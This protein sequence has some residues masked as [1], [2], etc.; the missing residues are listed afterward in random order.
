M[1]GLGAFL[2]SAWQLAIPYYKSEERWFARGLLA[3]IIA[4]NLLLVA[5]NVLLNFWNGQFFD[6]LQ[7][8]D[9]DGFISLLVF[10]RT[11][12]NGWM[13]GFT[14]IVLIYIPIAIYRTYLRQ[15][16]QIRW[17]GWL[18]ASLTERW[19]SDRAYYRISLL[20][21]PTGT[22]T[23]NPDQRIADDVRT[24]VDDA[25]I[26]GLDLLTNLVTLFSFL[27][28]LWTLSGTV[29]LLGV[30]IPG[31][32][33]WVALVYSVLG[34]GLAHL[35]GWPLT[36]INF[37]QER[38]EADFRFSLTRVRENTEGIALYG[39]EA[40]ERRT[41][42]GRFA[43]IAANWYQLIWRTKLL[44][45]FISGYSQVANIFPFV[46]AAPRYFAGEI[47][48]GG[49]TRTASAFG[50]VQD[51]MSWFITSYSRLASW[52]ATVN[53]LTS[54]EQA[55]STAKLLAGEG[56]KLVPGEG[57]GLRLDGVTLRLPDG[58]LLIDGAQAS[59]PAGQ[60]T[61]IQGRSGS[62]KSTLFRALAGI[63]PFG[64]G[65]IERPAGSY[66]FIPQRSYIPLGTLRHAITYPAPAESFDDARVTQAL[67]DAGLDALRDQ[68]DEDAQW[69]QRL[70]GG[71]QQRLALARA[72][73]LRPDWLF[74]DEATANLDPEA[75]AKLYECLRT[76]LPGT[77][78]ISIA[79]RTTV[80]DLHDHK[81]VFRR[82][83]GKPGNL[84]PA[85]PAAA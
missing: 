29:T 60:S 73:L 31:Y 67:S 33:V 83:V 14:L 28:V 25:L 52:Q 62:G 23:D 58:S 64:A 51:A 68:L 10:G 6:T 76:R 44:N 35:V 1:R 63:W 17:R 34:T 22:G 70:S 74:L 55:I 48:L 53:R 8:K 26:L 66:L 20:G 54:F 16:L 38:F 27:S 65:Q 50:Q 84:A 3:A 47:T 79:H 72:L 15:W 21:D 12:E 30:S 24:F 32:M 49:L 41:L 42:A 59:F 9:S 82:Q 13:P 39:G 71:E 81:L 75:E 57:T 40:E 85:D 11:N 69:A 4:L 61:V 18:T 56:V 80:A 78:I 46:V 45:A 77:T 36:S 7:N 19:L 43:N 2:R 37:R 5:F